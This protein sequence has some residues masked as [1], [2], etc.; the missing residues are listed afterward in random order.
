MFSEAFAFGPCD[1][2]TSEFFHV[3]CFAVH[4][5]LAGF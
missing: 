3:D 5:E 4:L 1:S 2:V